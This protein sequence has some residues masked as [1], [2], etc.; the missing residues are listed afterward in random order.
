MDTIYPLAMHVVRASF[1]KNIVELSFDFTLRKGD[2][3]ASYVYELESPEKLIEEFLERCVDA[4]NGIAYAEHNELA[5]ECTLHGRET[6]AERI[7]DLADRLFMVRS[8]YQVKGIEQSQIDALASEPI[9]LE[10]SNEIPLSVEEQEAF[11]R[12]V[13]RAQNLMRDKLYGSAMSDLQ[14][15]LRLKPEDNAIRFQVAVCQLYTRDPLASAETLQK[16]MDRGV[17]PPAEFLTEMLEILRKIRRHNDADRL[18]E[19]LAELRPD[20]PNVAMEEIWQLYQRGKPYLIEL[21]EMFAKHPEVVRRFLRNQWRYSRKTG[22]R[23]NISDIE[24][25]EYLNLSEEAINRLARRNSIPCRFH[26]SSESYS[27]YVEELAWYKGLDEK[28]GFLEALREE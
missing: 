26:P 15:C 11:D 7:G 28:Y 13:R 20:D 24:A 18:M 4:G 3:R 17:A 19:R 2:Y 23:E 9:S 1:R 12:L 8:T 21:N 6:V 25:A 10:S 27:F 16:L 22:A 14:Q 5:P